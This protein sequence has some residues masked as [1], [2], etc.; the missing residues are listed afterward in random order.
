MCVLKVELLKTDSSTLEYAYIYSVEF[1]RIFYAFRVS[2][3]RN[4]KRKYMQ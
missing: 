4:Y 2:F 3:F 1:V